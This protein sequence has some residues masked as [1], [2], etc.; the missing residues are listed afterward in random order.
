METIA[1]GASEQTGYRAERK[2]AR[3]GGIQGGTQTPNTKRQD[4]TMSGKQDET[5]PISN[6]VSF[7]HEQ[8][9]KAGRKDETQDETHETRHKNGTQ[10]ETH[11]TRRKTGRRARRK[12]RRN[13][14][15]R[16]GMNSGTA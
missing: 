4:K 12:A 9:V 1:H 6:T 7:P 11:E 16:N 8:A 15:K 14:E 13:I 10:G 5:V 2:T 3:K